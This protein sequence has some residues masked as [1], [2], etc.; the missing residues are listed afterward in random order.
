MARIFTP[1]LMS[2]GPCSHAQPRYRTK[3]VKSK[4]ELHG[5]V[6]SPDSV[7]L[8][9]KEAVCVCADRQNRHLAPEGSSNVT[10]VL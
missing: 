3:R 5:S 2:S 7:L 9:V 6:A 1:M 4:E 10:M 8:L